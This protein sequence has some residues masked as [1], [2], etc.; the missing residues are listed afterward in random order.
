ML[1][2]IEKVAVIG[3]GYVGL[4]LFIAINKANKYEVTG[5]EINQNKIDEIRSGKP[6]IQDKDVE[7]YLKHNQVIVTSNKHDLKNQDV[8]IICV[9]TPVYDDLNPDYSFVTA[10]AELVA[11]YLQAGNH[12]VL[13]STVNPGTSDE[14]IIPILEKKTNLKAGKDF[15]VAHCP[16]RIN[17]GDPKW[18]IYNIPRNIGSANPD[19]NHHI[20]DFYRS[21]IKAEVNE[22]SS[23]KIAEATKIVENTFRDINIAFVNELAQSFDAMGV[24]LYQTLQGAA[25]KPFG[26]MVH[27]PGCGVGGHC[28]AVDPYYLIKQAGINGFNHRF[29]KLAREI[30]NDMPQ[31]CI[32]RL[33]TALNEVGMPVK[34]TKIALLGLSYKPEVGD[35][36]QSPALDI[37]QKLIKL[38]ANLITYDPYLESDEKDLLSAVKNATAIV[39]ATAHQEFI[40]K[41]PELLKESAVKVIIDGRNCLDKDYIESMGIIYRGI[42]R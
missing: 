14:I 20:A 33:T 21:V 22:V 24:D 37:Q 34:D 9:P 41:L 13:E 7:Q 28:I 10:A 42:G 6:S 8:Y 25:N 5:Y 18:N 12:V 30:N 1:K 31:Y 36:R 17:P 2:K 16:E 35:L 32:N 15:N 38:Q 39:I 40:E 4:P 29:L 23:L 3:L 11:E 27:W 19:F 26:F